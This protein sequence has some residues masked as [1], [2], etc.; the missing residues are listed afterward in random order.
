MSAQQYQLSSFQGNKKLYLNACNKSDNNRS[1]LFFE[2]TPQAELAVYLTDSILPPRGSVGVD[3]WRGVGFF[4]MIE[5]SSRLN[6]IVNYMYVHRQVS[7]LPKIDIL[8]NY[9]KLFLCFSVP[10]W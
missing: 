2:L 9:D 7:I 4:R 8:A 5:K 1:A 10:V 6:V 3:R